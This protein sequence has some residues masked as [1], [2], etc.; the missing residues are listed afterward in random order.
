[1]VEVAATF[2]AALG[3]R[4]AAPEA[5][6]RLDALKLEA[7]FLQRLLLRQS[8]PHLDRRRGCSSPRRLSGEA[9]RSRLALRPRGLPSAAKSL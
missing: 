4:I 6:A 1:M 2:R 3:G 8:G 7:A 9:C 5:A